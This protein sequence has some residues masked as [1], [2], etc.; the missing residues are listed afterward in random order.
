MSLWRLT[1][2]RHT[3]RAYDALKRRGVTATRLLEYATELPAESRESPVELEACAADVACERHDLDFSVPF[4]PRNGE[5]AV[6]A[7]ADGEAVGRALVCP[8]GD[9]YVGALETEIGVEGAYVRKVFVAPAH[10][11]RGIATALVARACELAADIGAARATALV[12]A[13]NHPSQW[14]FEAVGFAPCREHAYARVGP[15]RRRSTAAT[16]I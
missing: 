2:N 5:H 9:P 6:V 14:V 3:R 11:G 1:R 15:W 7:L 13:D 10:R 12:A 8:A 4:S 16:N